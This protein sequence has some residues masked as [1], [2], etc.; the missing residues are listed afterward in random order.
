MAVY[1]YVRVSTLQQ[2]NEGESLETQKKQVI[3]YAESR[4]LTL[5]CE[6]VFI[7]KGVSGG[8]EF[9]SRPEGARLI[10]LLSSGDTLIFPKLDR[11]FRNTR[12][13]LNT[14]HH[15]KELG[16][17]VHSIDLGGD[18]TGNGVGAII[19]TILSAFA[20]FEK[21][22]IASRI[23]EVKQ[24]RKADGYFVGG[25][26]GFGFDVINGRKAPNVEEQKLLKQM[27]KMLANGRGLT[28][29]HQWLTQTKGVKLAYSSMRYAIHR[30]N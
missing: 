3:S 22:R 18:V 5:V 16:V 30:V 17:S 1:G 13:A 12:D 19:F 25:R 23:K 29:I 9:N 4:G 14:L 8:V 7:E 28:E 21:E 20:T 27:K 11:G 6:D 24:R 26:R 10:S 2:A 15:L